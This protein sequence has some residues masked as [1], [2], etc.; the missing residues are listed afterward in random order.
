MQGSTKQKK[1]GANLLEEYWKAMR[2]R[3]AELTQKNPEISKQDAMKQAQK[4]SATQSLVFR[5]APA[6]A[7]RTG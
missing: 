3:V 2:Q 7:S 4:E 6:V 1:L 5:E